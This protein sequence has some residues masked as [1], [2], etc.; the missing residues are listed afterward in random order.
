MATSRRRCMCNKRPG[1]LN[2]GRNIRYIVYTKLF[3]DC[4]KLLVHG[5][6]S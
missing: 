1:L 4:I 2:L 5:I 6:R 3:T